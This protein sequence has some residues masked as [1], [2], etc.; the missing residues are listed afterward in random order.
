M[1]NGLWNFLQSEWEQMERKMDDICCPT[2]KEVDISCVDF[3]NVCNAIVPRLRNDY[4]FFEELVV[5]LKEENYF[6][7][8]EDLYIKMNK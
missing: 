8:I 4:H 5:Y 1:L 7:E 2:L 3:E 6:P